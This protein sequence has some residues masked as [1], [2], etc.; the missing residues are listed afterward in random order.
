LLVQT[1]APPVKPTA[2]C[3]SKALRTGP[4]THHSYGN[5]LYMF[6]GLHSH[7]DYVPHRSQGKTITRS[8]QQL[9][10]PP[11]AAA[12]QVAVSTHA[13]AQASQPHSKAIETCSNSRLDDFGKTLILLGCG[14][15]HPAQPKSHLSSPRPYQHECLCL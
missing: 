14:P 15:N 5:A 12:A 11:S 13:C 2:G 9:L 8:W 3:C 6:A 7:Q 1:I 4:C 10:Q